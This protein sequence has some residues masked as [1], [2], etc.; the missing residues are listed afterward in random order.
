MNSFAIYADEAWTHEKPLNRYHFFFGG[1][2]GSCSEMQ[3][4]E[5]CLK[6]LQNKHNDRREVKWSNLSKRNYNLYIDFINC[7]KNFILFKNIK[8][9]QM[10]KDRSFHYTNDP[11]SNPLEAQ[12]KLYYQFLKHSFGLKYIPNIDS[13]I[14]IYLDHHSNHAH[15]R[16]L[17]EFVSSLPRL[18]NRKDLKI[19]ISFINS[20][21]S[22]ILQLC[23]LLMGA[24][25]YY[26]NKLHNR[27]NSGKIGMNS[28]QKLK[29]AFCKYVYNNLKDIDTIDRGS[30][31]FNW[32]ESTG[33]N[34]NSANHYNHKIR[35]WKF[36]PSQYIKNK[37]WENDHL[38]KHGNFVAD[39]FS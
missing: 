18:L 9:R 8:Y 35:I 3:E 29:L 10:F 12:Y 13:S 34:L 38:D 16:A 14:C 15:Q 23:D 21:K 31:A 4:L 17:Q 11:L 32:F 5:L 28:S 39:N 19:K 26:G 30:K 36:V 37:G 33:T 27:R 6:N 1:L 20:R 24:A 22:R 2:L 7:F 25:G